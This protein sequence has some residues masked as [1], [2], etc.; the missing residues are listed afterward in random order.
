MDLGLLC[1]GG[2]MR[3]AELVDF[4]RE[5]ET[6]GAAAFYMAEVW[7]SGFVPLTAVASATSRMRLGT[8]VLNAYGRSPLV[9][10]L[11]A[12][13]FN[14]YCG[15]RLVLG[16]G[17]G[18]RL[19]NEQWQG[20]PHARVL[21]KM[22][23]YVTLL[24]RMARTRLGERI[25]FEGKVHRMHWEPAIDPGPT[26]F[27]IYLAAVFPDMLKV[28]ARVADGIACGATLS[29]P[30]LREVIRPLVDLAAR[31]AGRDPATLRWNSVAF[32]AVDED[33]ERARRAARVALCHLYAPLPHP[34]YEFTMR[35]QGFTTTVDALLKLA[36]AG[37]LEA[38]ADSIPD[39]VIDRLVIAGTPAECFAR[40][41]DYEGVVDELLLLN[42]MGG[43]VQTS[44]TPLLALIRD[45]MK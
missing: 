22:A 9:T 42:A 40:I 1:T 41:K 34:Y 4:A 8:Y 11:S 45:Y 38:A 23:E 31:T 36:P 19:I 27:S 25:D 10:G 20:I 16:V 24:Q 21:T 29:A 30:Y 2:G 35:E 12:I 39:E 37:A 14:E 28:A 32:I 7:R 26:P 33:R 18:N 13:D 43:D 5:A 44:H 15:G 6:A 3:F 17:G